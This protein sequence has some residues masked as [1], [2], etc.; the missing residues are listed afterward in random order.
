MSSVNLDEDLSLHLGLQLDFVSKGQH[1]T[2][3]ATQ[4]A[5]NKACLQLLLIEAFNRA[6]GQRHV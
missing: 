3:L 4:Q 2:A 6:G 5:L 1:E